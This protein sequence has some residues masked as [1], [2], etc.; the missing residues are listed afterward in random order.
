MS[1]LVEN[2]LTEHEETV[3]RNIRGKTIQNIV[4][5]K[6]W[7]NAVAQ[8]KTPMH[9]AFTQAAELLEDWIVRYKNKDVYPPTII[10]ITDGQYTDATN[11]Q[12]LEAAQRLKGLK[13][14]DGGV[15]LFNLHISSKGGQSV[16]FPHTANELPAAD[17]YAKI[18]FDMSSDLPE[19][20]NNDIA[21][22]R[23][24]DTMSTFTGMAYNASLDSL[25][26]LM[27]IGTST[28]TRQIQ[29]PI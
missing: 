19:L 8:N 20:Y 18:L 3:E 2:Y 10:N 23:G 4:K 21:L 26:K 6:K 25:V 11:A 14:M 1:E 17:S 9:H 7:L 5:R 13:T 12:M 16:I 22:L 24:T 27:N 29:Q 15:L 28:T